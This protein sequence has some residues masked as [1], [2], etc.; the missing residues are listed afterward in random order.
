VSSQLYR[1]GVTAAHTGLFSAAHTA[2]AFVCVFVRA[3]GPRH[4]PLP[5][6]IALVVALTPQ[7]GYE[8]FSPPG[9]V[10]NEKRGRLSAQHKGVEEMVRGP[11]QSHLWH[12]LFPASSLEGSFGITKPFQCNT[13]GRMAWAW[14]EDPPKNAKHPHLFCGLLSRNAVRWLLE[15]V[16]RVYQVDK[17]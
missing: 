16:R 14:C 2:R 8:L 13:P 10:C 4:T 15:Q 3:G 9:F 12:H 7:D 6:L 11:S 17:I 1:H 5:L